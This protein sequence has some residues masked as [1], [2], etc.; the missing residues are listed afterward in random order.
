MVN[1]YA[2]NVSAPSFIKQKLLDLVR[3]TDTNTIT[4]GYL[5]V[6]LTQLESSIRKK[7]QQTPEI[8]HTN[9]QVSLNRYLQSVLSNNKMLI[10]FRN[11]TTLSKIDCI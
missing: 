3:E 6:P 11:N 10:F 7:N 8:N 2:S 9:E 5:N 1:I 4:V